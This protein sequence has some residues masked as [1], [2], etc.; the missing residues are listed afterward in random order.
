MRARLAEEQ[1]ALA[2]TPQGILGVLI[3]S[4]VTCPTVQFFN[5]MLV[6]DASVPRI[7]VPSDDMR[8]T[9]WSASASGNSYD[10]PGA[11]WWSRIARNDCRLA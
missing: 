1:C 5:V 4:I 10:A 8:G 6:A 3:L 2:F 9:R 7:R 11:V